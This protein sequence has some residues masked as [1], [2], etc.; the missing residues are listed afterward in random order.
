M[1]ILHLAHEKYFGGCYL[2]MMGRRA[3]QIKE[4]EDFFH[5]F[6]RSVGLHISSKYTSKIVNLMKTIALLIVIYNFWVFV[7]G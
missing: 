6:F 4:N 7:S 1:I 2:T 3:G 5:Y